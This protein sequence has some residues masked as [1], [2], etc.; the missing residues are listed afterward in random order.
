MTAQVLSMH[1]AHP[2]DF[3][4]QS[5][6]PLN[7]QPNSATMDAQ[8][9]GTATPDDSRGRRRTRENE[10][11]DDD[12]DQGPDGTGAGSSKKRRRSRKGLDK[13]FE[14]PHDGCGKSYSRAEHLY[15]HQ[16]NRKP[17][18]LICE[19]RATGKPARRACHAAAPALEH[20][21]ASRRNESR[22]FLSLPVLRCVSRALRSLG[23]SFAYLHRAP[24][25]GGLRREAAHLRPSGQPNAQLTKRCR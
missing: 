11:G 9:P 16:L 6:H 5:D 2:P 15:R 3:G 21:Q 17:R 13:K 23:W 18:R 24:M 19:L 7:L 20:H 10:D 8:P 25:W 22:L 1:S 14:C 4:S 12:M